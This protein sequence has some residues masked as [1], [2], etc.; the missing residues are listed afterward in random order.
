LTFRQYVYKFIQGNSLGKKKCIF[1][2]FIL[3]F[4]FTGIFSCKNPGLWGVLDNQMNGDT[5][6]GPTPVTTEPSYDPTT[7]PTAEPTP[8][9]LI[10]YDDALNGWSDWSW[11]SNVNFTS[12]GKVYEGIRAISYNMI[13]GWCGLSVCK[14]TGT[15]DLQSYSHLSFYIIGDTMGD[16]QLKLELRDNGDFIIG[17][18][19]PVNDYIEEG[20]VSGTIWR[21]V[22]IPVAAIYEGAAQCVRINIISL[23]GLPQPAVYIDII[24]FYY[25]TGGATPVPTA[26]PTPTPTP[27][28]GFKVQ[29]RCG[30][31][32]ASNN[33][34]K[35][36]FIIVNQDTSYYP[37]YQFKIRY[38][39]KIDGSGPEVFHCD[40]ATIGNL[41]ITGTFQSEYLEIGFSLSAGDLPGLG[42]SGEVQI[43]FHKSDYTDYNESNDYSFDPMKTDYTDWNK[44]T[45]YHNST[46]VWGTEPP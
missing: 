26:D 30:D 25:T 10:V 46:L 38:Y 42:T 39:Y 22:D 20:A 5:T 43:R 19:I 29:Y 40:Y 27:G 16:Q 24:K 11:G 34:I 13:S 23:Q 2:I 21:K 9:E 33:E 17:N 32:N 1:Y 15:V 18:Q 28:G 7:E 45:L 4:V 41:N 3:L 37:L 36:H 35:P 31:T 6:P 44:V 14:D 12:T 8:Q